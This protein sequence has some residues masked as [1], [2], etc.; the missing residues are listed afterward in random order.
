MES[1]LFLSLH[2]ENYWGYS[3]VKI[4]QLAAKKYLFRENKE[5]LYV[6]KKGWQSYVKKYVLR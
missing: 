5:Q 4:M 2:Y 3:C 6:E 1:I